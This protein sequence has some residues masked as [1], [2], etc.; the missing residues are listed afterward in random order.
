MGRQADPARGHH[1]AVPSW[2]LALC[3]AAFMSR[4]RELIV[5]AH[6]RPEEGLRLS[7]EQEGG[8]EALHRLP[9]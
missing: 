3:P 7:G 1:S 4:D 2:R 5:R 6:R 9:A 8:E